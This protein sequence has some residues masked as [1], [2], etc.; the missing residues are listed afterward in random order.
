MVVKC[1]VGICRRLLLI[2][3]VYLAAASSSSWRRGWWWGTGWW[4]QR[5]RRWW[6]RSSVR[7]S[8]CSTPSH[9]S[10]TCGREGSPRWAQGESSRWAPVGRCRQLVGECA[11]SARGWSLRCPPWRRPCSPGRWSR[12]HLKPHSLCLDNTDILTNERWNI[13]RSIQIQSCIYNLLRIFPA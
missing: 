5:W 4:G 11:P 3:Y 9:P 2:N 6:S 13:R 12:L 8:P 10:G 7:T 1:P